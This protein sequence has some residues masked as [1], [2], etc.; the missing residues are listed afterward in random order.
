[1][2]PGKMQV[3]KVNIVQQAENYTRKAALYAAKR[4]VQTAIEKLKAGDVETYTDNQGFREAMYRHVDEAARVLD[5][6]ATECE[7]FGD[8]DLVST[9][10]VEYLVDRMIDVESDGFGAMNSLYAHR[11]DPYRMLSDQFTVP[12]L[13]GLTGIDQSDPLATFRGVEHIF[14]VYR[15]LMRSMR[16]EEFGLKPFSLI[17][18]QAVVEGTFSDLNK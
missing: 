15:E 2:L 17:E 13:K 12:V 3:G 7:V 10:D 4:G 8:I 1:F 14:V 11:G 9:Q 18:S 5:S 16:E 6:I